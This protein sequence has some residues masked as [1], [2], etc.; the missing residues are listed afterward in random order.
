MRSSERP[1]ERAPTCT[2]T[3]VGGFN[4]LSELS[5][6]SFDVGHLR[7]FSHVALLCIFAGQAHLVC[8]GVLT[9][10]CFL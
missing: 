2:V 8:A 6:V 7:G 5:K 4:L 10:E 3:L 9:V 1:L